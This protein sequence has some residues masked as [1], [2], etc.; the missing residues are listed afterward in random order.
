MAIVSW[1]DY[2]GKVC[3]TLQKTKNQD[4]KTSASRRQAQDSYSLIGAP[5]VKEDSADHKINQH[6]THLNPGI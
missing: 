4:K 2:S 1:T 5:G 6:K 3:K